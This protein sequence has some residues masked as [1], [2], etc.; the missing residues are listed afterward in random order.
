MYREDRD[1]LR[2]M[3]PQATLAPA[4]V[5]PHCTSWVD[6]AGSTGESTHARDTC[7]LGQVS[8]ERVTK[9]WHVGEDSHPVRKVHRTK[10]SVIADVAKRHDGDQTLR[11]SPRLGAWVPVRR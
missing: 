4:P 6:L 3:T 1:T 11:V 5:L 10:E 8:H 9:G 2:A 7:Y